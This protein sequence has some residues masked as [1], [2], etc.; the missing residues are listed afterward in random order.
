M[1]VNN[2]LTAL[3]LVNYPNKLSA[4]LLRLA[5][6]A[7]TIPLSRIYYIFCINRLILLYFTF[8][9]LIPCLLKQAVLINCTNMF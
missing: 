7:I 5:Q 8:L 1:N 6:N 2:A 4:F 3:G 9:L